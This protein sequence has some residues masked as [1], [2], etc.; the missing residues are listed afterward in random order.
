MRTVFEQ[1]IQDLW[2]LVFG[3]RTSKGA[4]AFKFMEYLAG[5]IGQ[6]AQAATGFNIPN[7]MDLAQTK[8]FYKVDF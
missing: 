8:C 6:A 1:G 7:Q 2:D 4:E 5:P 3:K